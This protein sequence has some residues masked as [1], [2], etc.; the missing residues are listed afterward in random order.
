MNNKAILLLGTFWLSSIMIA[1]PELTA[2]GSGEHQSDYVGEE[3]RE[4]KTLSPEDVAELRNGEGWGLAR[5]AELNGVPGPA[6]LLPMAE[7]IELTDRQVTEIEQI[8]SRMKSRA[9]RLGEELIE[10]ERRLNRQFAEGTVTEESLR[11]TLDQIADVT[12]ELRYVHLETHLSTPALLSEDQITRY[13]RLR[14]YDQESHA[15]HP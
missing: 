2:R 7:E 10:L 15:A 13:G 6:H 1:S 11:A 5:A 4:I 14:G 9:I 12:A 3:S 8:Y